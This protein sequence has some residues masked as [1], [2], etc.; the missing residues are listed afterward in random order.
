MPTKEEYRKNPEKWK[1]DKAEWN[2]K[3][4]EWNKLRNRVYMKE[5]YPRELKMISMWKHLGMKLET[6]ENWK[7]MYK[8]YCETD[9]CAGCGLDFEENNRKKSLDHCHSTGCIRGVLCYSC[10]RLDVLDNIF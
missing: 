6:G 10:N 7:D 1:E 4:K 2:K 3:N 5:R 9:I 8:T